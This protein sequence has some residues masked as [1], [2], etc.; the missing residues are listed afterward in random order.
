MSIAY[1]R[2]VTTRG[3]VLKRRP[4]QAVVINGGEL[5][6]EVIGV[7]GKEVMIV[8]QAE[9]EFLFERFELLKRDGRANGSSFQQPKEKI[10]K[11]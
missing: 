3:L 9:K 10:W 8:F 7:R 1:K 6:I 5:V 4:G 11:K 2:E